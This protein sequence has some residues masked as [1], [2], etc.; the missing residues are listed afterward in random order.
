[1]GQEGCCESTARRF[2]ASSTQYRAELPCQQTR[3][4]R[5]ATHDTGDWRQYLGAMVFTFREIQNWRSDSWS[6]D[7]L[8]TL[9]RT[10]TVAFSGYSAADPVIHD[11][12]RSVYEDMARRRAMSGVAR[13]CGKSDNGEQT[14]ESAPAF[15]MDVTGKNEFHGLEILRSASRAVG[16]S[17]PKL[18]A[19]PNRIEF[20]LSSPDKKTGSSLLDLD[21]L[22][23]WIFRTAMR[24]QQAKLLRMHLWSAAHKV[25]ERPAL[26]S[27]IE[28]VIKAFHTLLEKEKQATSAIAERVKKQKRNASKHLRRT[29]L[30]LTTWITQFHRRLMREFAIAE[31]THNRSEYGK[32]DDRSE[33]SRFFQERLK[34]EGQLRGTEWYFP[35]ADRPAWAAWAVVVEIAIRRMVAMLHRQADAHLDRE[36]R[37]RCSRWAT[38]VDLVSPILSGES[39]A[40]SN[41]ADD[42]PTLHYA[43]AKGRRP[44]N[45]LEIRVAI[46][47]RKLPI[48]GL[49]GNRQERTWALSAN[50]IPWPGHES[51]K[52]P[53]GNSEPPPAWLLWHIASC[54]EDQLD[55]IVDKYLDGAV[56]DDGDGPDA[57]SVA[58]QVMDGIATFLYQGAER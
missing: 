45:K 34:A 31:A 10:R 54:T 50:S 40:E 38:N 52:P 13:R 8:Y 32:L 19:H 46:D 26:P 56:H 55:R 12:F 49:R 4:Y 24:Q 17:L 3:T 53:Y 58:K 57:G 20:T 6:R 7:L 15:F 25:W 1:M 37:A 48:R 2:A 35:L 43:T 11:T 22:Q 29:C 36:D 27:E 42:V 44:L 16:V 47:E 21:E 41:H 14:S 18:S 9:L 39:Q 30:Q 5:K 23:E 33:H 28:G 51:D